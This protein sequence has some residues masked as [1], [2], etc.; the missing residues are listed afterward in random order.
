MKIK[1][2]KDCTF[3]VNGTDVREFVEGSEIDIDDKNGN[4]LVELEFAEGCKAK[5]KAAPAPEPEV[6]DT[7][8]AEPE[9]ETEPEADDPEVEKPSKFKKAKKGKK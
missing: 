4:R 5:K 6:D 2:L 9:V 8:D 3:A 7:P 1:I